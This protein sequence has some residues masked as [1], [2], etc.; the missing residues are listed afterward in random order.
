MAIDILSLAGVMALIVL[1]V[2]ALK[3][4]GI[5]KDGQ[6]PVVSQAL[7]SV[8]VIVLLVLKEYG[9][10]LAIV[11]TIASNVASLGVALLALVPLFMNLNK[12]V[13]DGVKGLPVVGFSYTDQRARLAK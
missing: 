13:H 3:Q 7:Q 11:D 1:V 5:V 2:N 12:F 8:A 4:F 9:V 6:A 10:D